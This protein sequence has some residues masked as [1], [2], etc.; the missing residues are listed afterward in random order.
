MKWLEVFKCPYKV[1]TE[2]D[3]SLL[4]N[5]MIHGTIIDE[6]VTLNFSTNSIAAHATS[7]GMNQI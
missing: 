7:V 2:R 1:Y 6:A 5:R 3:T 4:V